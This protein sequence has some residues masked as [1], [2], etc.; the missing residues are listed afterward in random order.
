MF[1]DGE[2]LFF[3]IMMRL[4]PFFRLLGQVVGLKDGLLEVVWAD[5]HRS[6]IS[7]FR[8]LRLV[9]DSDSEDEDEDED[10][11]S[12]ES[13]SE[14]EQLQADAGGVSYS[15]CACLGV[16]WTFLYPPFALS[17]IQPPLCV[18]LDPPLPSL[19]LVGRGAASVR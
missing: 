2:F 10:S 12:E 19:F 7:P 6:S 14:A 15:F 3:M 18:S 1:R 9:A 8:C 16:R 17:Y 11:S 4:L 13:A 5:K